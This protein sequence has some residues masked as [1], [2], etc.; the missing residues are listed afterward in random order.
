MT[1]SAARPII[2]DHEQLYD[3]VDQMTDVQ[4]TVLDGVT[5]YSG[6]HPD[7]G[8]IHV[9]VPAF[10]KGLILT[11]SFFAVQFLMFPFENLTLF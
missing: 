6:K 11:I 5:T 1:D 4:K 8:S 3:H 2:L 7:L 9:V 10:G